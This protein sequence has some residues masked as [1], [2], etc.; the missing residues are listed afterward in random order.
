M[1]WVTGIRS[2]VLYTIARRPLDPRWSQGDLQVLLGYC[3][4]AQAMGWDDTRAFNAAEA[5][6]IRRKNHGIH[7]S[8]EELNRDIEALLKLVAE[9]CS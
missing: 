7:W 6:L 3:A 8:N 2:D 4:N 1:K 5:I 9:A